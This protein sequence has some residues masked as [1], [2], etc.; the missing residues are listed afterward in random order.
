MLRLLPLPIGSAI[1]SAL[2][3]VFAERLTRQSVIRENIRKAFPE[4]SQQQVHATARE[5][6]AN[7]GRIAAEMAHIERFQNG[8]ARGTITYSGERQLEL[9]RGGP[10][11][12]VGP[13]QWNW[14]IAP[15]LYV[16]KGINITTIY[17]SLGNDLINRIWLSQRHKTGAHYVEKHRAVRA[18]IETLESG[19]SLAFLM[20]QRVK[21]GVTVTFF[22]RET[23]MTALPARL[24]IKYRCPIVPMDMQRHPGHRF[25]MIFGTPIYPPPGSGRDAE[26]LL[27]QAVAHQLEAIIRKSPETWFCSKERWPDAGP[28]RSLA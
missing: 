6:A 3:R 1:M 15:L 17:S 2:M 13:H 5:V 12:F 26:R 18:V 19:G 9:A 11:I 7:L 27:T 10:V 20:D 25:H 28:Q 4:M 14:E 24:A 16:E 23:L 22:G 21:S 8:V